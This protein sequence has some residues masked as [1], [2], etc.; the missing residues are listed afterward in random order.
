MKC[1]VALII[2]ITKCEPEPHPWAIDIVRP[3][4]RSASMG[5]GR[6][7]VG[8]SSGR[9]LGVARTELV[10]QP[11][12]PQPP[13]AFPVFP[14]SRAARRPGPASLHQKPHPWAIGAVLRLTNG[15]RFGGHCWP[16]PSS[17]L[18]PPR[19]PRTG[20]KR[21]PLPR[22]IRRPGR[23]PINVPAQAP[24]PHRRNN[25]G[26]HH[27]PIPPRTRYSAQADDPA[28]HYSHEGR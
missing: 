19:P 22:R 12:P 14:A 13:P 15:W 4:R 27:R 6:V 2:T 16:G 10:L 23:R 1:P 24:G 9:L 20:H 21:I 5:H 11:F 7:S 28:G 26:P 18:G 3:P 25:A 8:V 17:P